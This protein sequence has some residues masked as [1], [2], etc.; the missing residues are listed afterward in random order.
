MKR[1]PVRAQWATKGTPR[2][3]PQIEPAAPGIV[4]GRTLRATG[5]TEQFATRIKAETKSQIQQIAR[6]EG[7]TMAEVIERAV[8]DYRAARNSR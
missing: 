3:E 5:R 6:E 4:D 2:Q 7:I 8:A 1:E